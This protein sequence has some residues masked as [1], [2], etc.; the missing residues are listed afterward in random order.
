MINGADCASGSG[1]QTS[2]IQKFGRG[3]LSARRC[4]LDV[5]A[6]PKPH[7]S[8]TETPRTCMRLMTESVYLWDSQ[9]MMFSHSDDTSVEL[10]RSLKY[11]DS[12]H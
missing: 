7:R 11:D 1:T 2:K 6:S 10:R 5:G 12:L 3:G 8:L 4:G 9:Q